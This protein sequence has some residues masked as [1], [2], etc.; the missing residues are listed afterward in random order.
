MP[1]WESLLVEASFVGTGICLAIAVPAYLWRR[2]P[3]ALRPPEQP[4][5]LRSSGPPWPAVTGLMI[6]LA[7]LYWAAGGSLGIAH[8]DERPANW[9]VLVGVSAFWVLTAS[10]TLLV[11]RLRSLSG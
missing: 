11:V 5:I 1:G 4:R 8:R 10:A 2:W 9:H 3:H 7:W 6:G